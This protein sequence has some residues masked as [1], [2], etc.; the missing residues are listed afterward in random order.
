M[1]A[2]SCTKYVAVSFMKT[3]IYKDLHIIKDLVAFR[4]KM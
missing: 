1:P 4:F 2:A 3:I